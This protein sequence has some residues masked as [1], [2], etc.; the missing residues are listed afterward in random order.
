MMGMSTM[1]HSVSALPQWEI[2]LMYRYLDIASCEKPWRQLSLNVTKK[3]LKLYSQSAKISFTFNETV[4]QNNTPPS[5]E[6][7]LS[8]SYKCFHI[9]TLWVRRAPKLFQ[10]YKQLLIL[11]FVI[12]MQ[13]L[14]TTLYDWSLSLLVCSR[15]NWKI[16]DS[17]MPIFLGY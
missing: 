16:F 17:L 1:W 6:I 8:F 13:V 9:S 12:S 10:L 15:C 2:V 3:F 7:Y 5:R 4:V 11:Y 14:K